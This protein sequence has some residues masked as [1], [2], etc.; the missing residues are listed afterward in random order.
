[1]RSSGPALDAGVPFAEQLRGLVSQPELRGLVAALRPTVP[2]LA[3]LNE[4]TIPLYE[5]VRAASSCQNAVILPWTHDKIDDQTFPTNLK[6]FQEAT[7][8]LGGLAGESRSGDANGQWFRVLAGGPSFAYPM[9]TDRFFLTSAP[10]LGTNPARPPKASPLRPGVPCE[11]QQA[12]DLRSIPGAAPEGHR[13]TVPAAAQANYQKIIDQA[14]EG[15]RRDIR[16]QGLGDQLKVS[17]EPV[18]KQQLEA[19]ARQVRQAAEGSP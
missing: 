10:L 14:A 1:V 2:S 18:T 17:T 15:L 9:G 3:Q 11:T 19:V 12:P 6:V 13:V 8:P 7:K 16:R 4:R 5:Q